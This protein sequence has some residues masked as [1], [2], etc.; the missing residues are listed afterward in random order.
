MSAPDQAALVARSRAGDA[1]AFA[2]LVRAHT[3]RLLA[4]AR[5]LGLD[6]PDAEDVVQEAFLRAWRS[7][8]RFDGRA[9]F[10]TWLH[11]IAVNETLRR[12]E[13]RTR[14]ERAVAPID[15]PGAELAD[16]A[17]GPAAAAQAGAGRAEVER[18]LAALPP[19]LRAAVVLRDVEGLSTREAAEVLGVRERA[20]KSRLH[21]GRL[22]L[23]DALGG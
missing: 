10:S 14:T 7:L 18:A 19:A 12:L 8:G 21:R 23:R 4:L 11:R 20:L 5:R 16:P 17:P 2:V 3:A 13:R 1:E 9:Q 15:G 22:A 6:G